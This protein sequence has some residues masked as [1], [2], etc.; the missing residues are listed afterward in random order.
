MPKNPKTERIRQRLEQL[1]AARPAA[2]E[3]PL[4]DIQ[5]VPLTESDIKPSDIRPAA[6]VKAGV[7]NKKEFTLDGASKFTMLVDGERLVGQYRINDTSVTINDPVIGYTVSMPLTLPLAVQVQGI[8][9]LV[10]LEKVML[11]IPSRFKLRSGEFVAS[12]GIP[13]SLPRIVWRMAN[14]TIVWAVVQYRPLKNEWRIT[15][16]KSTP[17]QSVYEAQRILRG[18]MGDTVFSRLKEA[19][20]LLAESL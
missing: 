11:K 18:I 17:R 3:E 9:K 20:E 15:R 10:E 6:S 8:G 19:I 13:L 14:R 7:G 1:K 16:L 5:E 4:A 2:E 12:M